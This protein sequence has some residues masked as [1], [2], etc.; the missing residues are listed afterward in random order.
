MGNYLA[1]SKAARV[2]TDHAEFKRCESEVS[3][4]LKRILSVKGKRGPEAL[5]RQLGHI[6]WEECGMARTATSLKTALAQIPQI[7]DEFWRNVSVPGSDH[8]LNQALER[9]SRL[10]DF[11]EFAELMCH[12]ALNRNESCGCHLREEYQT[13]EGEARRDDDHY[14]YVAAWEYQGP[15]QRP[16]LH[17]EPLV[18]ENVALSERSY[19]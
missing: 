5:H 17:K 15:D 11:L 4:R 7:R 9:A 1:T 10:A 3:D 2:S 19:K 18:F 13:A 12:D 16:A 8:G 14:R 6:M